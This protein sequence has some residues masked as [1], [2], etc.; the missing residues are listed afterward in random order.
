L[1][2]SMPGSEICGKRLHRQVFVK[3]GVW[4]GFDEPPHPA[5]L[6]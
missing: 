5:A 3:L 2:V 6:L 4:G 1:Q